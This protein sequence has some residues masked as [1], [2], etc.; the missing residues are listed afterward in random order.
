MHPRLALLACL[1]P[2]FAHAQPQPAVTSRPLGP[3]QYELSVRLQDTAEVARGQAAVRPM[4]EQLCAGRAVDW[5]RYTFESQAP[6]EGGQGGRPPS[7]LLRQQVRCGT[8]PPEQADA[9]AAASPPASAAGSRSP[10]LRDGKLIE[11]LTLQ[12]LQAKDAGRH[13]QTYA[14]LDPAMKRDNPPS[15]WAVVAGR[16]RPDAGALQERVIRKISWYDNPPS[17]P[18]GLYVA[19]DF[20]SRFEK[21]ALHCGFVIWHRQPD[22]AFLVLREESNHIDLETASK[23][24]PQQMADTRRALRC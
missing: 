12:Y 15:R 11:R 9:A 8:P 5:G 10:L 24:T 17:A 14:L 13:E 7:L 19:A 20:E 21:L 3:D 6:M 18:P 1:L 23:M 16:G 4:A 2:A 22:G